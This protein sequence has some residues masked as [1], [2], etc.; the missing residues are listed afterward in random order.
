MPQL[1]VIT[2]ANLRSLIEET[3]E[4]LGEL[5]DEFERRQE[6]EQHREIDN[7]E[8]H[9]KNAELSLKTIRD[10]IAYLLEDLRAEKK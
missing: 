3:E 5:K 8:T 6:T 1:K 10:F 2:T 9:L 4:S 7:L